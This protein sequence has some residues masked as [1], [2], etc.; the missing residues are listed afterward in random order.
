MR[1]IAVIL[2]FLLMSVFAYGQTMLIRPDASVGYL[3]AEDLTELAVTYGLKI[4]LSANEF[5]R[6]GLIIGHLFTPKNDDVSYLRTGLMVEQ[7]VF[8]YFNMGIGTIGYINLV[9]K[10]ENP[11]GLYS[12]LGFEYKFTKHLIILA[13]YQCDTIFR[14]HFTLNNAFL[15]GIGLQF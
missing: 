5:Q 15:F 10:G 1:K 2:I 9:E 3:K 13:S 7:V 14:K 11:F 12:H 4:H 8:R 6:Y